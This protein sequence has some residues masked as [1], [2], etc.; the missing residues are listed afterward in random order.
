MS[1]LDTLAKALYGRV[2]GYFKVLTVKVK[3]TAAQATD[4]FW[5]LC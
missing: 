3:S 1:E 5:Q 2:L 4:M